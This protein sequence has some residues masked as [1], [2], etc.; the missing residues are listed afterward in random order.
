MV[1]FRLGAEM[2]QDQFGTGH[3]V[4]KNHLFGAKAGGAKVLH[5][6]S[7]QMAPKQKAHV[8][9]IQNGAE[10]HWFGASRIG[11]VVCCLS[12][13]NASQTYP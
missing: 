2:Y 3:F 6:S 8:G 11:A 4:P 9:A 7:A 12:K 13:L 10:M 1:P 5:I